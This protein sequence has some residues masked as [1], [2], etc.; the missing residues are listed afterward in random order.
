MVL[1]KCNKVREK[2]AHFMVCHYLARV[3]IG[4]L[5]AASLSCVTALQRMGGEIEK[6]RNWVS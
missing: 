1:L 6:C 4:C 2:I 3:L 5:M